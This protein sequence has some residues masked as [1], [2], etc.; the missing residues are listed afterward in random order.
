MFCHL[1]SGADKNN[2]KNKALCAERQQCR[3]YFR[4]NDQTV[5]L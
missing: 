4:N 2:K 1:M 3:L 5:I